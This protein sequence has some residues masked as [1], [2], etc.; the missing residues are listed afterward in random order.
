MVTL[1]G[2]VAG[3]VRANPVHSA[4]GLTFI[5]E[6]ELSV[7]ALLP[8]LCAAALGQKNAPREHEEGALS[9]LHDLSQVAGADHG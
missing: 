8:T 5:R 1:H 9:R 6:T 7:L 4:A 2:E 3:H